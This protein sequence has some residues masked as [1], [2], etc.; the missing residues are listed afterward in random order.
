MWRWDTARMSLVVCVGHIVLQRGT[1][2]DHRE[3]SSSVNRY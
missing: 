3:D 2:N 1:M